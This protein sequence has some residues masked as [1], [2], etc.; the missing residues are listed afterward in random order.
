MNKQEAIK[1]IKRRIDYFSSERDYDRGYRA[2][3]NSALLFFRELDEPEKVVIPQSVADWLVVCKENLAVGLSIAMRFSFLAANDQPEETI[4][5]FKSPSNQE[6]FAKAWLFGY[7]VEKEKLYTVELPNP[8]E[9]EF[10]TV[11]SK[12]Y[13]GKIIIERTA[14]A[15]WRKH[16]NFQLT[17]SEIKQ[18][19][20]WAW[21]AGFAEEVE[22]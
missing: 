19:V 18:C 8:N 17:E 7:E 3:L 6:T 16:N 14:N 13:D 12:L 2:A 4:Q 1:K 22:E 21:E 20:E 5:W 10:K 15:N 11:L 9:Y